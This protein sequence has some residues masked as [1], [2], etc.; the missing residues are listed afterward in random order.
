MCIYIYMN[1]IFCSYYI[2]IVFRIHFWFG[3]HTHLAVKTGTHRLRSYMTSAPLWKP[4]T[5]TL[6]LSGH[7][8]SEHDE[9]WLMAGWWL[10]N[11]A[12]W[13]LMMV[14]FHEQWVNDVDDVHDV[15]D[16]DG[17]WNGK[18]D[19]LIDADHLTV[20]ES[21][22]QNLDVLVWSDW[23]TPKRHRAVVPF[24]IIIQL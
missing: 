8:R 23:H 2:H 12:K 20:T 18:L 22:I 21:N 4:R 13:W 3:F 7:G 10:I 19:M 24:N 16:V 15:H 6:R 9:S 1:V 17:D 14:V 5:A 11:G